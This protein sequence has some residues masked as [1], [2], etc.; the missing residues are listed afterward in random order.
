MVL[1]RSISKPGSKT[2]IRL[3]R[4]MRYLKVT[5]DLG[6]RYNSDRDFEEELNAYV[7]CDVAGPQRQARSS[8]WQVGRLTGLRN[9]GQS[10]PLQRLRRNTWP[11][12]RRSQDIPSAISSQDSRSRSATPH[13]HLRGHHGGNWISKAKPIYLVPTT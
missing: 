12:L 1:T 3:K 11:Y 7:A 6:M 2:L 9:R 8:T 5:I 4:G 13:H 10:S